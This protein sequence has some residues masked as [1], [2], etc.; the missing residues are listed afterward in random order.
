MDV[1]MLTLRVRD[2]EKS[3]A[4]YETLAGLKVL[5]RIP[6]GPGEIAFLGSGEEHSAR[7]ELVGVPGA[8]AFSGSGMI[9]WF[10][11]SSME[12]LERLH[13]LAVKM[14]G[15]TGIRVP[16]GRS[17]YFYIYDPDRVSVGFRWDA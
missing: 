1:G 16:D 2:L 11:A 12:E 5:R 14:G 17:R 10:S 9:L 4:F 8:P 7:L 6:A 15:A 3:I 13:G